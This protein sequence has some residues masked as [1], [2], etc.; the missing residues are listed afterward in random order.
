M[1]SLVAVTTEQAQKRRKSPRGRIAIDPAL[2]E[3]AK[4]R[5]AKN[6]KRILEFMT[7]Y[8]RAG[9]PVDNKTIAR[10]AAQDPVDLTVRMELDPED[11]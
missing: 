9:V 6:E 3:R 2:R 10:M 7:A 11:E 8:A 1:S 4:E 5:L